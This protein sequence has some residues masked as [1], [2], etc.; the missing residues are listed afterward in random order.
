MSEHWDRFCVWLAMQGGRLERGE[1][2]VPTYLYLV[3]FEIELY[4]EIEKTER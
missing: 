4:S 1:I 2:D 3:Q